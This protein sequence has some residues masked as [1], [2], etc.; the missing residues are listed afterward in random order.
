LQAATQQ[1]EPAP[2]RRNAQ[3]LRDTAIDIA[4][5]AAPRDLD[6]AKSRLARMI[7]TLCHLDHLAP[8]GVCRVCSVELAREE[9]DPTNPS[10]KIYRGSATCVLSTCRRR[11]VVNT[12]AAGRDCVRRAVTTLLELL[13]ADHLPVE[14]LN[15]THA[16]R[17]LAARRTEPHDAPASA[18]AHRVPHLA[19]RI[20]R[21][22]VVTD[23]L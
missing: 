19:P 1:A 14:A 5:T 13:A 4:Q 7:P 8:A 22:F 21:R 15:R 10:K 20:A 3:N 23:P 9:I 18:P 12:L 11:D 6:T 16:Q 2:V 17:I